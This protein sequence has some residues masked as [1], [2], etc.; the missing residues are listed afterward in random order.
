VATEGLQY[1]VPEE[2]IDEEMPFGALQCATDVGITSGLQ[3]NNLARME[4]EA[5]QFA[6]E[7]LMP[8]AACRALVQQLG[9]QANPR[10]LA[11]EFLVSVSAMTWRLRSLGLVI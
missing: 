10:R 11:P 9:K 5:N 6:A 7:L 4:A 1:R 2:A 3:V 8:E